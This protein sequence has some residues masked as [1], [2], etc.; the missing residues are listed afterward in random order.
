MDD[1][2]R[3]AIAAQLKPI[4]DLYKKISL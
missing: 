1:M 3:E 2:Q 4:A